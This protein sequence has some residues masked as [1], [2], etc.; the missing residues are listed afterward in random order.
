[1]NLIFLTLCFLP[2]RDHLLCGML[3]P[4]SGP[5]CWLLG[6]ALLLSSVNVQK[7]QMHECMKTSDKLAT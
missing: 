6:M 4:T 3:Y 5:T 7:S 2:I 1:M